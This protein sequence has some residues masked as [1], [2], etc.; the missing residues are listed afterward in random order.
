[1]DQNLTTQQILDKIYN[2]LDSFNKA[3][4]RLYTSPFIK[5][6]LSN[7]LLVQIRDFFTELYNIATEVD[8]VINAIELHLNDDQTFINLMDEVD[9][10]SIRCKTIADTIRRKIY[11]N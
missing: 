11:K 5:P 9:E 2:N 6:Y 4:T 10:L 1:M 3:I 7:D 8:F